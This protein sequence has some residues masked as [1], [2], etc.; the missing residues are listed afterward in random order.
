MIKVK[1]KVCVAMFV[2]FLDN[3]PNLFCFLRSY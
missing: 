2:V 1:M 3:N